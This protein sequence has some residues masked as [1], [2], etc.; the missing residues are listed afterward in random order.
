MLGTGERSCL[1]EAILV[2]ADGLVQLRPAGDLVL[3]AGDP[4]IAVPIGLRQR[5]QLIAAVLKLPADSLGFVAPVSG[6]WPAVWP[7][8]SA[9]A[10]SATG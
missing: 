3:M 9:C 2:A 6:T 7:C 5:G 8:R 10:W 1:T 4:V